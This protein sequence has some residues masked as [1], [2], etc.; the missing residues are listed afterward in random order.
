MEGEA[1]D[2]CLGSRPFE[3]VSAGRR[4]LLLLF[5][6]SFMRIGVSVGSAAFG[7]RWRSCGL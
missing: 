4:L 1:S 7:V 2:V 6:I 3:S 5:I